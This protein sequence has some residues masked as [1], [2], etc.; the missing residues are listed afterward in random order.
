MFMEFSVFFP[1]W[2]KEA[3]LFPPLSHSSIE[4]LKK[5]PGFKECWIAQNLGNFDKK[6]SPNKPYTLRR[7]VIAAYLGEDLL[8]KIRVHSCPSHP[9][10]I[11]PLHLKQQKLKASLPQKKPSDSHGNAKLSKSQ[12]EEIRRLLVETELSQKEIAKRY[13]ISPMNVSLI[14]SNKIWKFK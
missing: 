2:V 12:V 4:E 6:E 9:L 14:L 10:C 13:G 3:G 7:Q 5:I 8:K 1:I 11:N